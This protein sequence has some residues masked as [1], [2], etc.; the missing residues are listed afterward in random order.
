MTEKS[1]LSSTYQRT[2][3]RITS[4]SKWLPLN[5]IIARHPMRPSEPM[6]RDAAANRKSATE[7]EIFA[8]LRSA[9]WAAA[10]LNI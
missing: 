4:R 7:P 5:S 9:T 2:P 3:Y 8:M 10:I 1:A 6:L